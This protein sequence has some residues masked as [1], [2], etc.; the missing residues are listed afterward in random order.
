MKKNSF[1]KSSHNNLEALYS[2]N[3]LLFSSSTEGSLN[4]GL[5]LIPGNCRSF[6]EQKNFKGKLPHVGFASLNYKN[7]DIMFKNIFSFYW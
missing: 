5:D 1:D 4:K 6:K 3:E 2:E 7:K